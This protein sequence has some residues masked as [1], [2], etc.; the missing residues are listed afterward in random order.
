M[1]SHLQAVNPH[2]ANTRRGPRALAGR[3]EEGGN[4][5]LGGAYPRGRGHAVLLPGAAACP[6]RA[7]DLAA[8]DDR[9]AAFRRHRL[10]RKGRE[11]GIARGVLIREGLA[12]PAEHDRGACLALGYHHRCHLGPVHLLEIDELADRSHDGEGHPPIVLLGLGKS[13]GCD[14]LRLFVG[15]GRTIVRWR[16]RGSAWGRRGCRRRRLLRQRR[17]AEHQRRADAERDQDMK[18]H[19]PVSTWVRRTALL[20]WNRTWRQG[21]IPKLAH[22]RCTSDANFGINGTSN[23][24]ILVRSLD[25][26]F[27][28]GARLS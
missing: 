19:G 12:R 17:G 14:G 26:T 15:D 13:S 1:I 6:D 23:F 9:N 11:S 5:L 2:L 20:C 28:T 22:T 21:P 3:D 16:N 7:D 4:D 25:S 10:L 24:M 18:S 8:D 27:L